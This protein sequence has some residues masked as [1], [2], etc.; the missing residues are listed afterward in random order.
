[1]DGMPALAFPDV[2]HTA[3]KLFYPL[4]ASLLESSLI[5]FRELA[6]ALFT[7]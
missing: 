3:G 6:T 7:C 4:H 2:S 5:Y 1:M